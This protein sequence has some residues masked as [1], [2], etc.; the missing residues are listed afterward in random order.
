M[1]LR[2]MLPLLML[3]VPAAAVEIEFAAVLTDLD[4]TPYRFCAV[5]KPPVP[6]KIPECGEWVNHTL[7]LI[8][9]G[10]LSRP[11]EKPTDSLA[12]QVEEARR[13]VLARKIYPGKNEKHI[14][15][16]SGAEQTLIYDAIAIGKQQL[17]P[18]EK[19]LALELIDPVRVKA[20]LEK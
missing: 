18:V 14:V 7:G 5:M 8:G 2:Y 20:M 13:A 16:I 4:G 17:S 11:A 1:R 19:L 6:D 3:S 15:D 12:S 10:A 9:F